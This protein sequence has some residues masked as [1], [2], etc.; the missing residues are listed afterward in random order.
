MLSINNINVSFNNNIVF[1]NAHFV[2][3]TNALT[4]I[5]GESGIGKSTL[6]DV[7]LCKYKS[8]Y[9]ID[10]KEL[11]TDSETEIA[12]YIFNNVGIV[13]QSP[14]F[15]ENIK[16]KDHITFT[17]ETYGLSN[18][19][20]DLLEKLN[21][22]HVLDSFPKQLSG[23][24]R[25]RVSL[26]LALLKNP[27]I[28]ILDEPTA[29]L[30]KENKEIIISFLSEYA[31]SGHIVIAS[32]H[33]NSLIKKGDIIYS[34][35]DKKLFKDRQQLSLM[36]SSVCSSK[37]HLH[38]NHFLK[39]IHKAKKHHKLYYRLMTLLLGVSIGFMIVS[40]SLNN[41][42]IDN[43]EEEIKKALTT[44]IIVYKV[45][46]KDN[47]YQYDGEVDVLTN[48]DY[49]NLK[50][51]DNVKQVDWR[52]DKNLHNMSDFYL[53]E[54][55][56]ERWSQEY[57]LSFYSQDKLINTNKK[58][59]DGEQ[60]VISLHTYLDT[61]DYSKKLKDI[62]F[63][64]KEQGLYIT[65]SLYESYFNNEKPEYPYIEFDLPIPIYN[66]TGVTTIVSDIDTDQQAP[67]N[68]I[69]CEYKKV[70]LPIIG[71][72]DGE[73]LGTEPNGDRI[74]ISQ[75][76]LMTYVSE[77]QKKYP[78]SRTAYYLS[79]TNTYMFDIFPEGYQ[80]TSNDRKVDQ[81]KWTPNAYSITV[82]NP[83]KT[84]EVID[85]IKKL[86]YSVEA[87]YINLNSY[88][89]MKTETQKTFTTVGIIALVTLL[90]FYIYIKY[91]NAKDND[92]TEKYLKSMGLNNKQRKKFFLC[93]K[94][95][96]FSITLMVSFI[97]FF[98]IRYLIEYENIAIIKPS[99]AILSQIV[100]CC[101]LIEVG[102]PL[103]IEK[104]IKND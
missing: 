27:N 1:E 58:T 65:E 83:E 33:D 64:S 62:F 91:I 22:T 46:F 44:E 48:T 93:Q 61:K 69:C 72:I 80:L 92:N 40:F 11:N 76:L 16:I 99:I 19:E 53:T 94:A 52:Y 18:Y 8:Q 51:I 13:Y 66:S 41:A 37:P 68:Y 55:M 17:L 90:L 36:E 71:V 30:D 43:T 84:T 7:L 54:K 20:T 2:A 28:L 49:E 77:L 73:S 34:I 75:S 86:G 3:E 31:H 97:S 9:L 39:Y 47:H 21:I 74:Y 14:C 95:D 59:E 38:T 10:D 57:I 5:I 85:D 101:I 12:N 67:G 25:T 88:G 81:V 87:E 98:I 29:S 96:Y 82:D 78:D 4:L 56:E 24:E 63:D 45:P 102:I 79:E 26:F 15:Y 103:V 6:I 100:L 89:D 70:K 23:G 42:V 35:K 60:T 50:D 32:T 104:V